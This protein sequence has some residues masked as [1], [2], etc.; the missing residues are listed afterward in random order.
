MTEIPR[1]PRFPVPLLI[2]A[3]LGAVLT[4]VS[5]RASDMFWF[6]GSWDEAQTLARS[7]RR[8]LMLEFYKVGCSPCGLLDSTFASPLVA[9][10][11]AA[12]V[13]V[14]VEMRA[15]WARTWQGCSRWWE[16]RVS[17]SSTPT[18]SRA[19]ASTATVTR[20]TSRP[21][22]GEFDRGKGPCPLCWPRRRSVPTT[23][24]S[25]TY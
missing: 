4:L 13:S 7:A 9:S 19:T 15:Q 1:R 11:A 8:P 10:E 12:F 3:V 21:S 25:P 17:F 22:C 16:R 18:A 14:R 2:L 6:A 23:W 5:A 20:A 24:N